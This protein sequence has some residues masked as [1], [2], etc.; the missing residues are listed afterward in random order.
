MCLFSPTVDLCADLHPGESPNT[1]ERPALHNELFQTE[2]QGFTPVGQQSQC[3][4]LETCFHFSPYRESQAELLP[5]GDERSE[6]GVHQ[7]SGLQHHLHHQSCALLSSEQL[8]PDAVIPP[9]N[10]C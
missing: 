10:K 5:A 6:T 3:E 4:L 2:A 1:P 9:S 7:S 8:F